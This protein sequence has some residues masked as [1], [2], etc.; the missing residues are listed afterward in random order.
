LAFIYFI[1]I[2]E[3]VGKEIAEENNR[4]QEGKK[5]RQENK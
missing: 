3:G 5:G 1:D 2:C 4:R